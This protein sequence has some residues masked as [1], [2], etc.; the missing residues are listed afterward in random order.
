MQAMSHA[1]FIVAAYAVAV[2]IVGALVAW[3][4]LD[5]RAQRRTLAELETRGF[6]RRSD[7][8]SDSARAGGKA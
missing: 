6:T 2:V 1:G 4:A 7:R 5:Y 8:A 3:V